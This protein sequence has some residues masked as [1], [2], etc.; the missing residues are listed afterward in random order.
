MWYWI[1]FS[2][3]WI[4]FRIGFRLKVVGKSRI[5]EARKVGGVLIV[6]NHTSYFDPPVIGVAYGKKTAFLARKTLFKKGFFVWLYPR[7][8]AIPVDQE[9]GDMTSLKRIIKEL[10]N[11]NP[12]LIFP[13]GERS[14]DGEIHKGEA[15]VG[16]IIAKSKVSVL[17]M[18]VFGAYEALPKESKF[19]KFFTQITV[20]VGE[21]IQFPEDQLKNKSREAYQEISDKT[22]EAIKSIERA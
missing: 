19:P 21:M 12:V 22:I 1:G 14:L 16:L 17:P 7:L 11:G 4:L 18:R 15:G 3:A 9:R 5:R 6:A 13:E 10:R 8:N 20:C 2:C